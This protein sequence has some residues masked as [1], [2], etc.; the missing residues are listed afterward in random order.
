MLSKLINFVSPKTET[1]TITINKETT[2]MSTLQELNFNDRLSY[3]AWRKEWF[4]AYKAAIA[5]VRVGKQAFKEEQRKVTIIE[6][7]Y[8]WG[9]EHMPMYGEKTLNYVSAPNYYN[10]FSNKG[11]LVAEVEK[12]VGLRQSARVKSAAQRDAMLKEHGIEV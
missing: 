9:K 11:K 4:E 1:P 5:D 6:K 2:I 7:Q 8:P 10:W 12:L 3:L